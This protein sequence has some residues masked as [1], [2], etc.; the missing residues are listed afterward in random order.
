MFKKVLVANRGEIAVRIIRTLKEMGI[1]AVAIYSA[2]DRDSLHVQLADEAVCVGGPRAKDSYLNMQNILAAAV[3]TGAEAIHPGCGFLSENA[4]F[5]RLCAA[6]GVTFIGPAPETID[7][8]GNKEHAREQMKQAGVPVIPGSDGYV[9]TV[10]TAREVADQ[11]GYPVLLKAAAGGGGKG[12]RKI[13]EP[14]QLAEVFTQAQQEARASFGDDRMYLEKIM[15]NVKHIEVQVFRDA[16]GHVLTF[17]E[18]DCSLQR[19]KQKVIEESPCQLVTPAQRKE[20]GEIATKAVNALNYV[21]TGTL[22]FLMDQDH[23]FYFMEMNTRIQVEHTVTEM[24]TGLDLV[25]LQVLVAAG[26][27]L[28]LTQADLK[29]T[30]HAIEC[31]ICAEDPARGFLPSTGKVK[32]LYLPAGNLGMR[33]DSALYPG[34]TVS[35]YYDSTIAKVVAHASTRAATIAKLTRLLNELVISGVTTNQAFHLAL[36]RDPG[37]LAG[38]AST[39]Y[40][41]TS[42]LPTWQAVSRKEAADEA[43]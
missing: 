20:L 41:E 5:A 21:N 13:A 6:C 8:M 3:G 23:H 43:V 4:D 7:L 31:R 12:I 40:L 34:A 32:A 2:A 15:T 39:N 33:I 30:G 10:A 26:A 35:P 17:P 36:L 37:F 24:V 22:E 9:N 25:K 16:A 1:K 29:V 38:T 14:A 42:F 11:L 27:D 19:N 28:P 18:R